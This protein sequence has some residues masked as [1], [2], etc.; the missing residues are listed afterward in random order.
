MDDHNSNPDQWLPVSDMMSGLMMVFLFIAIVYMITVTKEKDKIKEIAVTYNKLQ[1]DLYNDLNNE[2]RNDL[3]R[4]NAEIDSNTI[5]VRF[6]SPEIL[7]EIGEASL[8]PEFKKILADFFPRYLSIITNSKYKK[9]IE[10]VRIEGHTSSE[11]KPGQTQIESYLYNMGLSQERS[12]NTLSYLINNH[13]SADLMDWAIKRITSNGLSFSKLI[14]NG[15][16]YEDKTRSRRVE[17]RVKTNAEE[18]IAKILVE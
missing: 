13:V 17:F 8:K 4:W 10:E 12:R 11:G 6:K 2:F 14:P 7:F 3:K 16:G 9:D 18:Q 1:K 5:S 15:T